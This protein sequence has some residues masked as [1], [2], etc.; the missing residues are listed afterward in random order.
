MIQHTIAL[1]AKIE[2]I[3][4]L[5]AKTFVAV[6]PKDTKPPYFI[7]YPADGVDRQTRVT[8]PKSTQHPRFTGH[9]VGASYDQCAAVAQLLKNTLV[10]NGRGVILVVPGEV[11]GRVWWESPLPI[12]V[13]NDVTPPLI[14]QVSECGWRSDLIP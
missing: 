6:A 4:A 7:L 8:G 12:Q 13:D 9:L 1:K 5:K 2:T 10:P 3:P 14:Y 11:C